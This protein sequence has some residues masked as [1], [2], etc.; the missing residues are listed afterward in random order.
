MERFKKRY[1]HEF[2]YLADERDLMLIESNLKQLMQLDPHNKNGAYEIRSVYFDDY[3]NSAYQ[4][5]MDGTS[6]RKKYRIR[7]YNGNCET[8]FLE[9]KTKDYDMT[10][11]ESCFL[12]EAECSDLLN[13]RYCLKRE[14]SQPELLR[15]FLAE[16]IL[17]RYKP[18]VMVIYERRALICRDGNVRITFDCNLA[19]SGYFDRIFEPDVLKRPVMSPGKHILE[20]KYDEFL[21]RYIKEALNS[22]KLQRTTFSKYV[23][24]RNSNQ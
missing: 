19:S 6:P 7:I 13:G 1:R 10:Y 21:P 15:R 20:V 5:N 12:S 16:A 14:N 18:V 9:K 2:K 3:K 17:K 22:G 23:L 4:E 11:K 24:C 8:I